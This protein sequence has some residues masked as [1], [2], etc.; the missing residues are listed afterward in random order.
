MVFSSSKKDFTNVFLN[1]N[2]MLKSSVHILKIK[3]EKLVQDLK[4]W[5]LDYL[6]A[7]CYASYRL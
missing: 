7:Y 2:I 6:D 1:F 4:M 5:N 3:I